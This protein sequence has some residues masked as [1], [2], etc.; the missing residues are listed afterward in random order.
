MKLLSEHNTLVD[1]VRSMS[2]YYT[3]NRLFQ[4]AIFILIVFWFYSIKPIA[5]EIGP[6]L[7][8][9]QFLPFF[10]LGFSIVLLTAVQGWLAR[11]YNDRAEELISRVRAHP[12]LKT[13]YGYL[14]NK[15]R[16]FQRYGG[17][18]WTSFT[19]SG[20]FSSVIMMFVFLASLMA[21]I[22]SVYY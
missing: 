1:H 21:I 11:N 8:F 15:F 9:R 22:L 14:L 13:K 2:A 20:F 5:P 7:K 16:A 6:G 3:L 4:I 12:D 18:L 17:P 10:Y 19:S